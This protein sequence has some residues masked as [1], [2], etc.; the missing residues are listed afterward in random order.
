MRWRERIEVKHLFVCLGLNTRFDGNS[1]MM[2]R[3][4]RSRWMD[5]WAL[6]GY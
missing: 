6:G 5:G 4:V 3:K 1:G 2:D